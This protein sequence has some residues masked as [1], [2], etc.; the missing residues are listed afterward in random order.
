M[1]RDFSDAKLALERLHEQKDRPVHALLNVWRSMRLITLLIVSAAALALPAQAQSSDSNL[2]VYA[3]GVINVAPLK[4][5]FSA[6]GVYLGQGA[7][8]TVAHGL[9]HWPPFTN[10][11]II[12]GGKELP[13]TV[14]KKGSFPQLDL[15][16]LSVD[17]VALPFSLRL[18]R[19]P[20][21]KAVPNV[22]TEVVVVYLDRTARSRIIS[23]RL[24]A[25]ANRTK[26]NSLLSEV[27]SSGTGVFDADK[28]CLVGIM[29]ASVPTYR[30]KDAP[31]GYFVPAPTITD[32][33][34]A[35][36]RF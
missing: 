7:I 8:I 29:S 19:E 28:K 15:G 18:R 21:C 31:A 3:I 12:I 26:F 27:Q 10:P 6:F 32:F 9:S 33:L 23:P 16:L 17:E 22:G 14:I 11:K 24:I 34:P 13:A 35:Q 20:L 1:R 5:P 30:E 25:P 4:L 36:Y 2:R